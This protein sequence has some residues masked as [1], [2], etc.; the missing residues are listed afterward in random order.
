MKGCK[1]LGDLRCKN[2]ADTKSHKTKACNIWQKANGLIVHL[3]LLRNKAAANQVNV[4]DESLIFDSHPDDSLEVLSE[5]DSSLTQPGPSHLHACH[6]TVS[7]SISSDEEDEVPDQ[8]EDDFNPT[9]A[10][11]KLP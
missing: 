8:S 2:H 4:D 6:I 7:G 11:R 3:W 5:A 9:L 1:E 10:M